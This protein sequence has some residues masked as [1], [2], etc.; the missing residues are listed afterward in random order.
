[1][2]HRKDLAAALLEEHAL[3]PEALERARRD[4]QRTGRPLWSVL[5]DGGLCSEDAVFLAL[6]RWSGAPALSEERLGGLRVPA[7]LREAVPPDLA[8]LEGVLPL[9]RSAD[10]RRVALA[11]VDPLSEATQVRA[12]LARQG[13][14]EIHR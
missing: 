9:E 3:R 14:V 12:A 10:G 4:Q 8:G 6:R 13:V 2:S 11:M 7:E 5:L 1:M